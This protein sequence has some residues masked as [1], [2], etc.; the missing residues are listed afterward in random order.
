MLRA[1][2][3]ARYWSKLGRRY[4][5]TERIAKFFLL[6]TSS[7][8]VASWTFWNQT[9]IAWKS[10]SVI[11]ALLSIALP[12]LNWSK[13]IA[14]CAD[15]YGRWLQL[16]AEHEKLFLQIKQGDVPVGD[17]EKA[18]DLIRTKVVEVSKGEANQRIDQKMLQAAYDEV[19]K[20]RGLAKERK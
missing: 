1:D 12:I 8:T 2:M 5:D 9:E 15:L 13:H 18:F 20:S 6:A 10:L 19:L 16:G 14:D 17:I 3:N 4:Y 7:S 11:S